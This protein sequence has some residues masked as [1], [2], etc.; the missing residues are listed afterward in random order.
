MVIKS[1]SNGK[2]DKPFSKKILRRLDYLA[3]VAFC[4]LENEKKIH[5]IHTAY[6]FSYAQLTRSCWFAIK[7]IILKS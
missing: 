3:E 2:K 6:Q 1:T 7:V 4:T 5:V